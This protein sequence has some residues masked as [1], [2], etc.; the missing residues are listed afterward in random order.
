MQMPELTNDELS[1]PTTPWLTKFRENW[2]ANNDRESLKMELI[3]KLSAVRDDWFELIEAAK[4]V[5]KT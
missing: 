5:V 3:S 4:L 1:R 2:L